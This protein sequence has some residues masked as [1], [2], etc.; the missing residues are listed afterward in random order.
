MAIAIGYATA[1]DMHDGSNGLNGNVGAA[2][3]AGSS[4]YFHIAYGTSSSG[5]NFSQS[6]SGK[7]YIGTYVDSTSADSNTPSDYAWVL[8]VGA[9]GEDGDQGI[10]G[11]NGS[12]GQTSYFHIA[13]ADTS[14]GGGFSQSPSN[15]NFIGTYVDN[16]SA[17]SSTASDYTWTRYV[18]ADGTNGNNGTNGTNGNNGTNGTNGKK[19]ASGLVYYQVAAGSAPSTPSASS[20]QFSNNTL[21]GLTSNWSTTPPEVDVGNSNKYWTSRYQSTESSAGS[22]TGSV[23]FTSPTALFTF[24]GVVSFT[25]SNT[26]SDGSNSLTPLSAGSAAADVNANSTTINGGKITANSVLANIALQVGSGNTPSS[27]AFEVNAAGVVWTDGIIGGIF[28]AN[29]L[30]VSTAAAVTGTTRQA[31]PG[32]FGQVPSNY[33]STSA[34]GIRGTNYY[35]VGSRVQTS[36][37]IGAANGYDFYA[38]GA[39]SNYGP[40]TGAH[41]C[42]VANDETV[43]MGDLV[44][45]V[46]CI[47]R[48]GLSNTIFSV[49]ASSSANQVA[50]LGVIVANNGALSDRKPAAFIEE[51]TED[52][53]VMSSDYESAKNNYK[54][55]AVN[56]LGEG[57]INLTGEGGNL[58]AGD[59]VVTS[60]TAGKGMKQSDNIVRSHTVARVR[61]SVSFTSTDE[62]KIAACIYLCG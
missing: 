55:M 12:N 57:Q 51:M 19:V 46:S 53:I 36:G 31:H 45:D 60:S 30:N 43:S 49:E 9:D 20:Y 14:S 27:K 52:G 54:I 18:G 42:L 58:L 33:A 8:F 2:G 15:K 24:D 23:S 1:H 16:T 40:F 21:G 62:E 5:A 34:H 37:L 28:S 22:N 11:N 59:L 25:N 29:N 4:T 44:V 6:P 13:Y 10:A 3:A 48:R 17:D 61:E 56:A 7:T 50:V 32:V 47:A 41:D 39:G 35:T 26:I 38:E